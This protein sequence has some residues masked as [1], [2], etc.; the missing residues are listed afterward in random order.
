MKVC[1]NIDEI[2]NE[3]KR[4]VESKRTKLTYKEFKKVV[5]YSIS[6]KPLYILE[7]KL[8]KSSATLYNARKNFCKY[9]NI[10][11]PVREDKKRT[12]LCVGTVKSEEDILEF[13]YNNGTINKEILV[14]KI[15]FD[16]NIKRR[17]AEKLYEKYK[18]I[19]CTTS[20]EL[21]VDKKISDYVK[22]RKISELEIL[23]IKKNWE[24]GKPRKVIASEVDMDKVTLNKTL[25][26]LKEIGVI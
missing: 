10:Q 15:A 16:L 6:D 13:I 19:Y 11:F 7:K 18:E 23:E 14:D 22:N 20:R 21:I 24:E 5:E 9:Y 8:N 3:M 26:D 1:K 4:F 17:E 12:I 25:R 2:E